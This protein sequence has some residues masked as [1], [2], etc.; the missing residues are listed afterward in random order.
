[1]VM[2]MMLMIII[3]MMNDDDNRDDNDDDDD[4]YN[5]EEMK[6]ICVEH[7]RISLLSLPPMEFSFRASTKKVLYGLSSVQWCPVSSVQ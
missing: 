3:M 2:M 5:H 4:D 1:M 7:Q 6:N